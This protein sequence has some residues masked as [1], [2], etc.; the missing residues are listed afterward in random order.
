M[1]FIL[2]VNDLPDCIKSTVKIFADDL[3]LIA[4]LSDKSVVD[5]DLKGLE[6]WERKWLLE[7][8]TAKCK[9][10]HLE[11]NENEHSAYILD[12]SV[13]GK[14]VQEKDLGVLTSGTLLW[15]DQIESCVGKANQMLCWI[16]RNLISREK[17]L[18]LRI[19]KTLVRPHLEYCVQL[20]N[21]AA[22]YG[23]WSLIMR[24]EGVQ[25][26]FTRMIEGVGLYFHTR[27]DCRF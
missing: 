21:P 22:E 11:F 15:N 23:N 16:S 7:F 14:T 8:N 12:D 27:S 3:K 20:W 2:F 18:M 9:V 5:N 26:R 13:L 1:I 10:L 25:R 4:N 19:Y 6:D 17:S 24:I